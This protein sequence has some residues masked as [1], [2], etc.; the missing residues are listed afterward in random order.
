VTWFVDDQSNLSGDLVFASVA[1]LARREHLERLRTES[2]DY[3]VVDEVHHAAADSYRRILSA[4]DP[5]F[6]L[7]LTAT[8]DRA[9]EADVLD[10]HAAHRADI[11]R[12]RGQ[13]V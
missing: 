11:A 12:C 9:D 4:I 1:K 2:F 8:P 7:G 5:G 10:D 13:P 3:V 6:L